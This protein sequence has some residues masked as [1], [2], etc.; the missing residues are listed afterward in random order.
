MRARWILGLMLLLAACK[1]TY[2]A[3]DTEGRSF[4][5]TCGGTCKVSS[6]SAPRPGFSHPESGTPFGFVA[7][8]DSRSRYGC[9]GEG[10]VY[11]NGSYDPRGLEARPEDCRLMTCKNDVDCPT[12]LGNTGTCAHG[13]CS[14]DPA[15][16]L[17]L[18]D[19]KRL[20]FA[21][22]GPWTPSADQS[23]RD[24]E[25]WTACLGGTCKVPV[26]CLQP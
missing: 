3:T 19:V 24:F 4:E 13:F 14:V 9:I 15:R 16:P 5:V 26:D 8:Y 2:R 7:S 6:T 12:L 22:T 25:T 23:R 18:D 17:T 21:G 10:Y 1:R 20:C 11:P